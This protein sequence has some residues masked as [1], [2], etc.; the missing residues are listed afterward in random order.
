MIWWK[1]LYGGPYQLLSIN[2]FFINIHKKYIKGGLEPS[3]SIV[4][5][6]Q[7]VS[8]FIS[9]STLPT[10]V[11][12]L[13]AATKKS[14][15]IIFSVQWTIHINVNHNLTEKYWLT[16]SSIIIILYR[17]LH[18][19]YAFVINLVHGGWYHTTYCI[20]SILYTSFMIV[21]PIHKKSTWTLVTLKSFSCCVFFYR[22]VKYYW[23]S[24]CLL[25]FQG[26]Y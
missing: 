25:H 4:W 19:Y 16:Y 24:L 3:K 6:F 2:R 10:T 1:R 8:Y 18:Y 20:E 26:K 7:N 21:S 14:R 11:R 15:H 23:V 5:E 12:T 22:W 9:L 17:V 13:T